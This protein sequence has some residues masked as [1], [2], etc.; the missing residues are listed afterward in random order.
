MFYTVVLFSVLLFSD[1]MSSALTLLPVVTL[2]CQPRSAAAVLWTVGLDVHG[3]EQASL[4]NYS[5]CA[6]DL[7]NL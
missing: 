7:P 6:A 1:E 4:Q 5:T 2:P 3:P